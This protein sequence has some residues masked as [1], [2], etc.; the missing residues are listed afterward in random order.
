MKDLGQEEWQGVHR[1]PNAYPRKSS[2]Q[3]DIPR[4]GKKKTQAPT[5][6]QK[7]ISHLLELDN[8]PTY[9]LLCFA[10]LII[11]GFILGWG[12]VCM[13]PKWQ[14]VSLPN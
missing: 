11:P 1:L 6:I 3:V 10:E 5:G 4:S 13:T 8:I 2:P 14:H 12:E 9:I 7:N